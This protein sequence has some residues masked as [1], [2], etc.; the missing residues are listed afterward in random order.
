MK[1]L[2]PIICLYFS[3][4]LVAQQATDFDFFEKQGFEKVILSK[5]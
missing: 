5:Y 2:V 3:I 4:P 1:L